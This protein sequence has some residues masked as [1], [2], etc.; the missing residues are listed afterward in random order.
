MGQATRIITMRE[1]VR[2]ERC[3]L[4]TLVIVALSFPGLGD[5]DAARQGRPLTIEYIAHACFRITSPSGKWI[6]EPNK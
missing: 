2:L 5:Q 1:A 6:L 4:A 3:S